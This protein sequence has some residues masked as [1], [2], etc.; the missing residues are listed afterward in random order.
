[1]AP[2]SD[3]DAQILSFGLPK[4]DE[5][6]LMRRFAEAG[7]IATAVVL[8]LVHWGRLIVLPTSFSWWTLAFVL[9]GV[10]A[11]DFIS[12]LIHWT[13]D[14][15]GSETM[16]ILGRRFL[17][18]FRVHHVNPDDFLRR[19]FLDTN[20]DVAAI[21]IPFLLG[22]FWIS[23]VEHLGQS[24]TAC[25]LGFCSAGLF[26]NQM[27]Q[28]AHMPCPPRPIRW[29]QRCRLILPRQ[30]HQRHH[31]PPY[32]T[33]YCIATGWCNGVLNRIDFFRRLERT[34]TW[35][36]GVMPR[37][38]DVQFQ[39]ATARTQGTPQHGDASRD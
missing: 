29:M 31:R 18:P 24:I 14:T 4:H 9:A 2:S 22:M 21:V 13:A 33:D 34:V 36:T 6:G 38:D 20:G 16:P 26:T 11:A 5:F 39:V 3:N 17:R 8:L 15:W 35:A 28:W 19:R 25:L 27:H 1:M 10:V 12:G 37:D 32:A 7:F 23:P 30:L